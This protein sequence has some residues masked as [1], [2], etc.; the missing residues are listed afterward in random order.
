MQYLRYVFPACVVLLPLLAVMALRSDPRRGRWLLAGVCLLDFAFQANGHW[1]LRTGAL[2]ETILAMGDDTASF[3][4]YAPE[5]ILIAG[6]RALPAEGNVLA[7]DPDIAAVAEMGARAR[8]TSR[9]D[10]SLAAQAVAADRDA[11]GQAWQSLYR[12]QG[13]TEVLLRGKTLTEARR[14]GLRQ[15]NATL[16]REQ[17][18]AQWWSLPPVQNAP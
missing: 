8:T 16:H 4:H 3:R 14:N 13:I 6:L 17:G 15:A 10:P 7:L 9:Y 12:Q 11:S 18:D 1:M 2:K 5:R